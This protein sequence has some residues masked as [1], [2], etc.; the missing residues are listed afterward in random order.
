MGVPWPEMFEVEGGILVGNHKPNGTCC[1]EE[2]AQVVDGLN[3]GEFSTSIFSQSIISV[4]IPDVDLHGPSVLIDFEDMVGSVM[5]IG[6]DKCL[7]VALLVSG[8]L[9]V[10]ELGSPYYYD[11]EA[12]TG[13]AFGPSDDC[14]TYQGPSFGGMWLPVLIIFRPLFRGRALPA[15]FRPST[16]FAISIRS[17]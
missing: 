16:P 2:Q 1:S 15:F 12:L 8:V 9:T 11:P 4:G 13:V 10:F 3:T 5:G 7:D 17:K 6:R 14:G